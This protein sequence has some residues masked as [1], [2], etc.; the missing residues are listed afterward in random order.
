MRQL[1]FV[2]PLIRREAMILQVGS[3]IAKNLV[4]VSC[5]CS[6]IFKTMLKFLPDIL[7]GN[8]VNNY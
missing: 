2:Y 8:I 6:A 3:I 4:E 1:L 7:P 5:P